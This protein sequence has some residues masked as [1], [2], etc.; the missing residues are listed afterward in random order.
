MVHHC[1]TEPHAAV[2]S[3]APSG[4]VTVWT[5]TQAPYRVRAALSEALGVPSSK[6]RVIAT[7]VGGGF[8]GKISA[9]IEPVCAVLSQRTNKPVKMVLDRM[10]E[11][12][13]TFVRHP[14]TIKIKTGV[15]FAEPPR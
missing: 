14:A 3:I 2:A 13:A 10:E 15:K 11:F 12:T 4:K 9:S 1:Y 8:G 7:K 5:N 6:I